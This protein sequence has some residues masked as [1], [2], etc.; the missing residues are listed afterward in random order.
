MYK[1]APWSLNGD[2]YIILYKFKKDF[3][4]NNLFTQDFLKDYGCGGVGCV[5]IVDYKKSDI[6]PYRELLFIPGKFKY[7]DKKLNTISKIYVTTEDSVIN[8][9]RNWAIPKQLCRCDILNENDGEWFIFSIGEKEFMKI[10][11]KANKLKFPVNTKLMPFPLIQKNLDKLYFTNFYGKGIGS[12]AKIEELE[13]DDKYFPNI[14]YFKPLSVI[15]VSNFNI[16]FPKAQV[17]GME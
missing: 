6:G 13:I 1:E 10:K 8:G 7:K 4:K 14:K 17:E 16:V 11:F 9:I 12:F 15:K 2:G 5:M 3:I